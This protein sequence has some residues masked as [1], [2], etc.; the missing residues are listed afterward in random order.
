M[1]ARDLR[2]ACSESGF[3]Y[4][5]PPKSLLR[6]RAEAIFEAAKSFSR[7]R[8]KEKMKMDYANSPQFRGYVSLGLENTR[9]KIDAREQVEFGVHSAPKRRKT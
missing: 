2:R 8:W 4:L 1:F 3:F 6:K 5:K 7:S 9:G